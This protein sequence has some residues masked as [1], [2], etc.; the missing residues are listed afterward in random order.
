MLFKSLRITNWRQFHALHLDFHD[1]LTVLTGANGSG[2]TT[3]L[4]LLS[5]HFGWQGT[6]VS[7]PR[8]RAGSLVY[9]PD[10][11]TDD[12]LKAYSDWLEGKSST[13]EEPTLPA[14][15]GAPEQVIGEIAY[16][17]GVASQL[18]VPATV[19]AAFQVNFRN[20]QS[21]KGIHIPSHRPIYSYQ[22]VQNIPTIPRRRDQT[23]STYMSIVQSRY[24]GGHHQWT[25]N[26][27][28]KETLIALAIFGPGNTLVEP[29]AESLA[30]FEG[31]QTVLRTV[32]PPV[33][34]FERLTIRLPEVV[35]VTKTG[36][37][38]LDAAS[39]GVASLIDLA[40]QIFMYAPPD[41]PFVVTIDE[42]ENHLHPELQ[43]TVLG[44]FLK[45]FPA[46]QFICATHNPFIVTS[47][48][49]SNTYV[50]RFDEDHRVQSEFLADIDRTGSSNEI[51]R[52][53][54]GL[55]SSSP[56]WVEQELEEVA[57]IAA[58]QDLTPALVEELQQRLG[59]LGLARFVPSSLARLA[60]QQLG[61]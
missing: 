35:L 4:N 48:P 39:G 37:F 24:Y 57:A 61:R 52:D 23:Y 19:N 2:K 22:P 18:T 9:F 26:Y 34:G 17:T 56:T 47:V 51:L 28:M 32:L 25:P 54:L 27:Y 16:G 40:W 58:G 8:R 12:W 31:F 50:L 13:L 41:T 59:A 30:T 46:V 10:Y 36:D 60:Q 5:R 29:D 15:P 14:T 33:L 45:A 49:D 53:V 42:P 1:R 3:I 38:S 44:T 55:P 6:L 43:R 20:Q 7:T 11:W 21:I